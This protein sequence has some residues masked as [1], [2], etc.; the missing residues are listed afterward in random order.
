MHILVR[1]KTRT[2]LFAYSTEGWLTVNRTLPGAFLLLA[3]VCLSARGAG[4]V[5]FS[6]Q[7]K[8]NN[9]VS[10]LLEVAAISKSGNLFKFTRSSDGWIFISALYKGTGKLKVVLNNASGS[11]PIVLDAADSS[12]ERSPT[13]EAMRR[14]VKGE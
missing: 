1:R 3:C 10:E 2:K 9:L 14:M 7:K 8:Q 12:A 5:V 11:E 13:A 4:R 6:G